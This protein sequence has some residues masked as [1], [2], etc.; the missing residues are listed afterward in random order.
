MRHLPFILLSPFSLG[1]GESEG[2]SERERERKEDLPPRRSDRMEVTAGA[3]Y[4][5]CFTLG[6]VGLG[7]HNRESGLR[8]SSYYADERKGETSE[9]GRGD[10]R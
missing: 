2:E 1:G 10:E 6:K 7:I 8:A 9:K 3:G 4:P 5:F